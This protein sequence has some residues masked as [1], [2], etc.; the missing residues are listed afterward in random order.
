MGDNP[1]VESTALATLAVLPAL[2]VAEVWIC[3]L[4]KR[5]GAGH[6][7]LYCSKNEKLSAEESEKICH[8]VDIWLERKRGN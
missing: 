4:L 7:Q 3:C 2:I 6:Q 5:I 1:Q 8:E